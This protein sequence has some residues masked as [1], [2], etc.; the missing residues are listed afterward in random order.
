[1]LGVFYAFLSVFLDWMSGG[2]FAYLDK[3]GS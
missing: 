1:L 2:F 3:D